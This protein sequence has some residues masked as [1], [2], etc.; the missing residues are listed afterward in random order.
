MPAGDRMNACIFAGPTLPSRENLGSADTTWL[1]PA[2]HGD[3]YRVVSLMRP[4]AIGIVDGYFQW[5]PSVWH[6][7]ILWAIDKGVHVFGAASMGALRAAELAPFGMRGVGRIFEAYRDGVLADCG[8]APFEDD[9]EVAVI[10]GPA[11]TGYIAASEAMVNIRYTLAKAESAGVISDPSR[12]H[13]VMI[14]KTMFFPERNYELLLQSALTAGVPEHELA[15]LRAWLPSE[16]INQKRLDALAM[17]ETMRHFLASD[18][19]AARANF[20]FE[21]TTLWDRAIADLRPTAAHDAQETCVLE[22]L[23]LNGVRYNELREKVVDSL[24]ASPDENANWPTAS[25]EPREIWRLN[26][27]EKR[28]ALRR[29]RAELP[30]VLVERQMLARIRETNEYSKL[31]ERAEDKHARLN[32]RNDLQ[33]VEDFADLQLLQ[34]SD[35]Y[36]A[37]ILGQDM[38]DDIDECVRSWGYLNLAEFHRAIFAEYIYREM[39]SR[40]AATNDLT[41]TSVHGRGDAQ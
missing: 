18:P 37:R 9:D 11:E 14:A 20:L 24:L 12:E 16:R 41:I 7:E 8:G 29:A 4:R 17:L 10:H 28:E 31:L 19:P 30:K 21:H 36:F 35:W 15:A 40:G 25:C 38:P 13:L 1:P 5:T 39:L 6:K 22:E 3:V 2:K 34:L 32:E 26:E 33:D 23:R 27:L